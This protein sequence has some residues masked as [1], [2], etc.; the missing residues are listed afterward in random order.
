MNPHLKAARLKARKLDMSETAKDRRRV[1]AIG[2]YL[3]AL[4]TRWV[5][6]SGFPPTRTTLRDIRTEL[7]DIANKYPGSPQL[8]TAAG[9]V[10][11]AY[12]LPARIDRTE[13]LDLID[14]AARILKH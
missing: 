11:R 5:G 1:L 13:V 12:L 4:H 3:R 10:G 14:S 7:W 6:A 9:N 8:I 2:R